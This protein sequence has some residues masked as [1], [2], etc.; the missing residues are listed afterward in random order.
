MTFFNKYLII[1][2]PSKN[3]KQTVKPKATSVYNYAIM[4]SDK[5]KKSLPNVNIL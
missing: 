4:V 3:R 1:Y 5:C 2:V